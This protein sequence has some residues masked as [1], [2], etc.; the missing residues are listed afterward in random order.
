MM[1]ADGSFLQLCKRQNL[2]FN[3]LKMRCHMT[4]YQKTG[5]IRLPKM[6]LTESVRSIYLQNFRRKVMTCK[7]NATV[8]KIP[9]STRDNFFRIDTYLHSRRLSSW[10]ML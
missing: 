6:I 5:T 3:P 2:P 8:Q 9:G 7:D 10:G 1:Y 4:F